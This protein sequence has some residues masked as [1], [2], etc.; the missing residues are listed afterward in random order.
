[1]RYLKVAT[2]YIYLFSILISAICL[3]FIIINLN[4]RLK[5][6]NFLE[7]N[8]LTNTTALSRLTDRRDQLFSPCSRDRKT[9]PLGALICLGLYYNT[10]YLQCPVY[11]LNP[12]EVLPLGF[13]LHIFSHIG[14]LF[15]HKGV[16]LTGICIVLIQLC[17]KCIQFR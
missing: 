1:M 6:F 14:G 8:L 7:H 3:S 12:F 5:K 4:I 11:I 2:N 13:L 10:K 17:Q 9:D 16:I 15:F